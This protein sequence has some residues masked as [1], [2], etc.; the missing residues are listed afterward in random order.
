MGPVA[1][2]AFA[3]LS[4]TSPS[5]AKSGALAGTCDPSRFRFGRYPFYGERRWLT[6]AGTL[7]RV[8]TAF[9]RLPSAQSAPNPG[10]PVRR[11][12]LALTV[13]ALAASSL[14]A[15]G[16]DSGDAGADPGE[17]LSTV[18]DAPEPEVPSQEE[19]PNSDW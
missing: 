6:P 13:A 15:C 3:R 16:E 19:L 8:V 11:T 18:E 9:P 12:A 14:A 17:V 2:V 10:G 4:V 7:A 1:D 5:R